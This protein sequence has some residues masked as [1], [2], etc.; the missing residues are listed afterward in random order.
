MCGFRS[1]VEETMA[2][3][4]EDLGIMRSQMIASKFEIESEL[5]KRVKQQQS[6]Q[7]MKLDE[8]YKFKADVYSY[9]DNKYE[10][11]TSTYGCKLKGI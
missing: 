3:Q 4:N 11:I 5:M 8:F 1:D 7:E 10:S 9:L 6:S 2:R